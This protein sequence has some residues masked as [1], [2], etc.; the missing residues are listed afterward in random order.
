MN[1]LSPIFLLYL[2][3]VMLFHSDTIMQTSTT[4]ITL[5]LNTLIPSLFLPT[6][7]LRLIFDY[8][9]NI[10]IKFLNIYNF[11]YILIGIL[12]GYP[13]FALYL[14]E[15]CQKGNFIHHNW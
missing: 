10:K 1:Y 3:Y 8:L 11:R 4:T 9:P 6:L 7:L 12:F 14:E 13:N 2:L 5:W 15:Q